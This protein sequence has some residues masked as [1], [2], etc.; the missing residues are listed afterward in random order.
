MLERLYEK[1]WRRLGGR[2]W[3]EIVRE[4]ARH[5]PLL[6][7]LL[8]LL[9]GVFLALKARQNWWHIL[10]GFGAGPDSGP[11]VV[12]AGI[13]FIRR[14]GRREPDCDGGC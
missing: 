11:R 5:Q 2:P 1:L 12:V 7:L 10:I 4:D 9:A 8:F 14:Q 3:T 13:R 6:Y